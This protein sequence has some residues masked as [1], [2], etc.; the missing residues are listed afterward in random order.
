[1]IRGV[2]L[3]IL[4]ASTS[5][6]AGDYFL[7]IA[8][9]DTCSTSNPWPAPI[10]HPQSPPISTATFQAPCQKSTSFA[11]PSPM[12]AFRTAAQP[13]EPSS[14]TRWSPGPFVAPLLTSPTYTTTS[15]CWVLGGLQNELRRCLQP[16]SLL[17]PFLAS[18]EPSWPFRAGNSFAPTSA[19]PNKRSSCSRHGAVPPSFVTLWRQTRRFQPLGYRAGQLIRES[20]GCEGQ[21]KIVSAEDPKTRND[22]LN[23]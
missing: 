4:F 2:L 20:L 16:N 11:P 12:R 22:L 3:A 5:A 18:S 17:T 21:R 19:P 13:S 6:Q 1:M 9:S 10:P 23:R 15:Y 8:D 7:F 14:R